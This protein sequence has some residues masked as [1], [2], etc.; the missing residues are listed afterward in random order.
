MTV[1]RIQ[2]RYADLDTQGHVNNLAQLQ[3]VEAARTRSYVEAG[4]TWQ[5]L[6]VVRSQHID[7]LAPIPADADGVDVDLQVDSIGRTSHAVT[8]SIKDDAGTIFSTGRCVVITVGTDG[9]P[10]PIPD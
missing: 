3:Y 5:P 4:L 9:R 8:F 10:A 2:I 6:Q 1:W 7:Y